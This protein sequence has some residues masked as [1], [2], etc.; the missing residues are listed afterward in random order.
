MIGSNRPQ[1]ILIAEHD[2]IV[3]MVTADLL[4]DAGFEILEVRTTTEAIA[5]L[6]QRGTVQ[7]LITGRR[8]PGDGIA[9]A[10]VVHKRWP[11]VSIFVTTGAGADLERELPPGAHL[12]RKP[13][14]F[15][16]LLQ[17]I[18]ASLKRLPEEP[19]NSPVAAPLL[20]GGVPVQT[21]TYVR[22]GIGAVAAPVSA[23]DKA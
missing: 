16:A 4:M 9:L 22:G 20:P 10:H 3:R 15:A 11:S 1:A 17:A 13:Y 12:F 14:E 21:G 8:I 7:M 23:P 2:D 5:T 6:E 18:E 19:A